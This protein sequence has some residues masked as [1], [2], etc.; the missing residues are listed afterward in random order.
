MFYDLEGKKMHR[1]TGKTSGPDEFK[2][3]GEY[4]TKGIYKEMSFIRYKRKIRKEIDNKKI[5]EK[6][7]R[8]LS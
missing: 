1:H 2:L 5:Q 7:G 6:E 4:L 3:M 8:G